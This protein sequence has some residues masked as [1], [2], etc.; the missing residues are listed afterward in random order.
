MLYTIY[1]QRF[2]GLTSVLDLIVSSPLVM[3][4]SIVAILPLRDKSD[5]VGG[6]TSST[7]GSPEPYVKVPFIPPVKAAL[8]N[9]YEVSLKAGGGT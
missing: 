2:L 8:L 5:V 9:S 7:I 6:T 4:K 3:V 1:D